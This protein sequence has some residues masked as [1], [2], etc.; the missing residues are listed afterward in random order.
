MKYYKIRYHQTP[1]GDHLYPENARGAVWQD[2]CYHTTDHV[3]IAGTETVIEPDGNDMVLLT[4]KEAAAL[5]TEFRKSL[6]PT[7]IDDPA[8]LKQ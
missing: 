1:Q 2:A 4:K 5:S 3:M 6:P 7:S 8:M